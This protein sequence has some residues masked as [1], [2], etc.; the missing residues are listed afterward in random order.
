MHDLAGALRPRYVDAPARAGLFESLYLTAH[1]PTERRALWLRHTVLKKPGAPPRASLWCTWFAGGD[2]RAAKV[3]T[4]DAASTPDRPLQ[5]GGHAWIGV[6]GAAG[7]VD[8]DP[9]RARWEN[10]AV[11]IAGQ[12]HRLGGLRS[13]AGPRVAEH[14]RGASLAL[15]GRGIA[16]A[17]RSD[18]ELP[19]CVAWTYADPVG[20]TRELVNSSVARAILKIERPG[21]AVLDVTSSVC[22]FE[23]GARRRALDVPLQPFAD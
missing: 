1:H 9:L 18:V 19:S 21:R 16:V 17:V 12:R 6:E 14:D 20:R 10:G 22:A 4:S 13:G 11:S 3:S 15:G 7:A 5:V 23:I 8:L 2:V